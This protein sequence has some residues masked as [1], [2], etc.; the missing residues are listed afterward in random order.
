MNVFD[1][2]VFKYVARLNSISLA[3]KELHMTQPAITHIINKLEKRY[4]ITLF[5]R[6]RQGT[7]LT[8]NGKEFLVCV[9]RL[10]IEYENLEE[11]ALKLKN[12]S[13]YKIVLAT[14]PSVT[15][16]CLAECIELGNFDHSQYVLAV[17]EGSYQEVLDWLS[18]GSADFSI[19]IKENLIQGF[20]Y[21]VIG[22]DPYVMV[23]S[24]TIPPNLTIK[25]LKNYPFIMPLSG[26]KEVLEP[27]LMKNEITV[28]KVMESESI[29]SAL[30]LTLQVNGI[31]IV[32][33]SGLHKQI[34]HEFI[35]QPIEIKIPR[36]LI[37]QWSLKKEN[38]PLFL[39]FVKN[40][41]NQL[42][43]KKK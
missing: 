41:L 26:C 35:V 15:V 17:R 3:A 30:A 25:E 28:N 34:I 9:D 42:Q 16:Y 22:E 24:K 23:S 12:K 10:L 39:A 11:T 29:S 5:D 8:E 33:L 4:A 2:K 37:M 6:S 43:Q 27:Y 18:S 19:S 14:Y 21:E 40:L 36:Q 1:F 13:L 32:P 31:T 20:H 38:D 7:V